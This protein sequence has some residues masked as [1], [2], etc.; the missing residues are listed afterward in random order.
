MRRIFLF[1]LTVFIYSCRVNTGTRQFESENKAKKIPIVS[2]PDSVITK[3]SE[4]AS[5][6]EYIPLKPSRNTPVKAIDKIISRGNKIYINLISNILCF[7]DKGNFL[8]ELYGNGKEKEENIVAIYNFDIDTADAYLI[9]LYGNKLLHFNNTG[10]GFDYI[11]VI[12]LGRL[13]PSKLDFV[14]GTN[15]IL[16]TSIRIMGFEPSLHILINING[17]TLWL[18]RN[19]FK[20]FNPVENRIWD[21]IIHYKFDNKL[22]FREKDSLIPYFQSILNQTTLHRP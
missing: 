18:K 19:Y 22:H 6:I 1:V 13:S 4:I 21:E 15:N 10:S 2:R 3:V 16:L 7:D 9:V 12:K 11:K 17:D 8:Y 20:R 5:D 14:P